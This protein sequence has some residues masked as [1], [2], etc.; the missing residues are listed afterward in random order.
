MQDKKHASPAGDCAWILTDGTVGM[1]AQGVAVARAIGVPFELKT[2]R[3][4]GPLAWLPSR[5][6]IWLPPGFFL[7]FV[8]SSEPLRPPWPRLIVSVGR[9]GVASALALKRL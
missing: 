2:V 3:V 8:A 5:M 7:R 6:Q 1:V 4:R 9:Q